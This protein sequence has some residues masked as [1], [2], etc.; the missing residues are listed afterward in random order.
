MG[1]LENRTKLGFS[2]G[3]ATLSLRM[4]GFDGGWRLLKKWFMLVQ[5]QTR[6]LFYM[7]LSLLV[8]QKN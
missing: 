5:N 1:P 4:Y 7:D 2:T 6:E 3:K 8:Q